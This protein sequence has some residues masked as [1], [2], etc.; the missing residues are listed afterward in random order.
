MKITPEEKSALRYAGL[1]GHEYILTDQ[2]NRIT[3]EIDNRDRAFVD[4]AISNNKIFRQGPR[5]R[6]VRVK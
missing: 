2:Q 6:F 4:A 1:L 5:R 3:A